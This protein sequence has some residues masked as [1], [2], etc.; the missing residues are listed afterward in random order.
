MVNDKHMDKRV[1]KA[2]EILDV[3]KREIEC[4]PG[5]IRGEKRMWLGV[6]KQMLR[7]SINMSKSKTKERTDARRDIAN[8]EQM[9][10]SWLT[11][12]PV[13]EWRDHCID[14]WYEVDTDRATARE[15]MRAIDG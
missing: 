4:Q 15:C 10:W 11:D 14:L 7:D 2:I 9:E 1:H 6:Y 13:S 3:I 12:L 5:E 8:C